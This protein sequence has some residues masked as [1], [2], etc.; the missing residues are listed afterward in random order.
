MP[1]TRFLDL[2]DDCMG[3]IFRYLGY[4]RHPYT[5]A[6]SQIDAYQLAAC[7]HRLIAIFLTMYSTVRIQ[8]KIQV[9]FGGIGKIAGRKKGHISFH[10]H[11]L[12][13]SKIARDI[14]KFGRTF[15]PNWFYRGYA[16]LTA[17]FWGGKPFANCLT[18]Y[19][20]IA[21]SSNSIPFGMSS[22][23]MPNTAGYFLVWSISVHWGFI[24]PPHA[25]WLLFLL[26]CHFHH[27]CSHS[28]FTRWRMAS[29]RK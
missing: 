18:L 6:F 7:N 21:K 17:W 23:L 27:L 20:P 22:F 24:N 9:C 28:W 26:Q 5:T 15:A 1:N 14:L 11:P 25:Y 4:R 16:R 13:V 10:A 12:S 3:I 8:G 2:P 19:I 29:K